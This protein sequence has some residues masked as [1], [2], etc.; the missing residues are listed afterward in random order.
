MEQARAPASRLARGIPEVK[1]VEIRTY[2]PVYPVKDPFSNA[3]R[4][5]RERAF[6]LV[7]IITDAGV[8]GW[9]EGAAV[10]VR[11]ALD[12]HVL[13]KNPFDYE[14]IWEALHRHGVDPAAISAVDIALWDAMGKS[15]G[16]PIYQ[17]LGGSFRTRVQAY[18]TGLFRRER[19][20]RTAALV[21]EA[22]GYV[23]E[24]FEA[25][26]MK[27]GF[28]PGYDITNVAAVRRAI[29]DDILFAVDANCGYDVGTAIAVGRE[30]G[31]N[32]LLWFEEPTSADDVEGHVE[33]RRALG[34]RIAGAEQSR[35]RWAFRRV[36]Q[37]R[38]LD[39]VQ[40]DVCVCGGITE[41][42]RI[43]AMA[44]A[45]HV[46]VIPHMFGTAIRLAAT[47][48]LLAATPDSPRAHEPFPTLL[49]YDMTENALRTE[50]AREPIRHISGMVAVPQAP[51]LGIEIDRDVLAKYC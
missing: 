20:D 11:A 6:G 47:L 3:M 10:P 18:A 4:T 38:A 14:V 23:D 35:G 37:E 43:A 42:R 16:Q 40:P 19:T 28:G 34:M 33:I 46:R 27:V 1:I 30:I 22:R 48:H 24:G 29:G 25:M 7:E 31:K 21:E 5:T 41:Y 26:K 44:S 32:N 45:N 36:I 17:M 50:L 8:T 9:G 12:A 13:G 51:G 39:I 49:E 2:S 15:L